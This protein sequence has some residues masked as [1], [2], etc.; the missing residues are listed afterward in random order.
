MMAVTQPGDKVIVARDCHRAVYDGLLIG[1]LKASFIT[2][3]IESQTS[4]PLGITSVSLKKCI[5]EKFFNCFFKRS[6]PQK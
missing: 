5:Q 3:L 2:P 6:E 1:H 4:I